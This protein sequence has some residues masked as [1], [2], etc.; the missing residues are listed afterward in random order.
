YVS[1]APSV[2][3][4]VRSLPTRRSSDLMLYPTKTGRTVRA[5][6]DVSLSVRSGEFISIVG[7]S[8]CGKST[9]LRI[10]MGLTKQTSGRV[11]FGPSRSEEH[12]S[13]LQSRENLVCRL[14][15]EK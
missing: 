3:L 9:L 13:E 2:N 15:L 7:P 1:Q 12:T 8:G 4:D 5:L 6:D 14:L 11:T 10:V